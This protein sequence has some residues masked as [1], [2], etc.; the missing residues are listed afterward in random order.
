M[1][2]RKFSTIVMI[3]MMTALLS[4]AGGLAFAADSA[5]MTPEFAAKRENV[6]KQRE[7]RVTPAKRKVAA[8]ALKAERLKVYRAKQAVKIS[9]P[10]PI[11][12]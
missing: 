4:L 5:P 7:Q 2:N 8:E 1:N 12:N 3:V 11:K 9:K 6:R 10:E